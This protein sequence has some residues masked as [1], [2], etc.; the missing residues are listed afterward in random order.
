MKKLANLIKELASSIFGTE[1]QWD[2]A[3]Y[4]HLLHRLPRLKTSNYFYNR[5][6][7]EKETGALEFVKRKR[8]ELR[9]FLK[10]N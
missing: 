9:E 6:A 4:C 3:D 2:F 10:K 1:N 7:D 8:K 5:I